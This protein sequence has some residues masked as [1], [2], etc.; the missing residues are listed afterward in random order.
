ML[1][2]RDRDAPPPT[3]AQAIV[4]VWDAARRGA[5][6]A[7]ARSLRAAG[8]TADLFLG[9][10]AF[11]NQLKYAN[12]RGYPFAVLVGPSEAERGLVAVKD[13]R[14]GEQVVLTLDQAADHLRAARAAAAGPLPKP[15]EAR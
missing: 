9:D 5:A 3:A 8:I 6:I 2:E 13:L 1:D 11:K 14:S 12:G 10:A 4:L 7:A 15:G